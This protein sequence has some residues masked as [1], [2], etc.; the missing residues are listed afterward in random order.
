MIGG[1]SPVLSNRAGNVQYKLVDIVH[2]LMKDQPKNGHVPNPQDLETA[3][4]LIHQ[5]LPSIHSFI[6]PSI[7]L[8]IFDPFI[9]PS[10]HSSIH[11]FNLQNHNQIISLERELVVKEYTLEQTMK[12]LHDTREQVYNML[13]VLIYSFNVCSW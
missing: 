8:S 4:V 6:H 7:H 1:D 12:D 3:R 5:V 9:H 10:I 11:S 2:H 13:I